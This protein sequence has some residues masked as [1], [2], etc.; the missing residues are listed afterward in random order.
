MIIEQTMPLTVTGLSVLLKYNVIIFYLINIGL[1]NGFLN[2]IMPIITNFGSILAWGIICGLLYLFGGAKAKKV[3]ILGLIALLISNAAVYLLKPI[4]AEPRPFL[5]LGNVHQ[6]IPE[7]EIYSFPSGHTTS[8]FSVATLIGLK[9][10][11]K[12]KKKNFRLIYPL[13]AFAAVI[14]FSRIY[15]GV[16]YPLDVVFGALI[17]IL[18]ALAVLKLEVGIFKIFHDLKSFVKINTY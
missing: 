15:V 10:R 3:A 5:A 14:G 9:Y 4:I 13:I 11:L 7:T 16:H 2:F 18:C 12:L 17:G 8:S 6:L 1:E